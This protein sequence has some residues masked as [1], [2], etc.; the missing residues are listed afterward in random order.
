MRLGAEVE[1]EA[2]L[3]SRTDKPPIPPPVFSIRSRPETSNATR[4]VCA[5]D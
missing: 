5:E 4:K 1:V 2:D 3:K